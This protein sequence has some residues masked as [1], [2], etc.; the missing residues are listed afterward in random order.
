[1]EITYL[2]S[3]Y[4]VDSYICWWSGIPSVYVTAIIYTNTQFNT[5]RNTKK[6]EIFTQVNADTSY[7]IYL[8]I[9]IS[10]LEPN[11]ALSQ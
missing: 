3:D 2:Q 6:L 5:S 9:S 10:F 1:M 11:L 8:H 4:Q 7:L